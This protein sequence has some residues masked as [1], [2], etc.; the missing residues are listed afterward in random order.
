MELVKRMKHKTLRILR[1]EIG[2]LAAFEQS[3]F[4]SLL[5]E[6]IKSQQRDEDEKKKNLEGTDDIG[7]LR[8]LSPYSMKC[9]SANITNILQQNVFF[10]MVEN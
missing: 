8:K 3:V 2:I 6:A 1:R 7:E 10:F 4:F 9:K 5:R